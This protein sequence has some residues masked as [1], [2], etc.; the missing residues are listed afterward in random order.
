MF[1]GSATGYFMMYDMRFNV[2]FRTLLHS[3]KSPIHS[4]AQ[5]HPGRGQLKVEAEGSNIFSAVGSGGFEVSLWNCDTANPLAY[6]TV[7]RNEPLEIP[8]LLEESMKLPSPDH[9][10]PFFSLYT[11]ETRLNQNVA[12]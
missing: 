8:Y 2:M 7:K 6:I 5:M 9:D 10:P 3:K 4:L 12:Y 11:G 1:L